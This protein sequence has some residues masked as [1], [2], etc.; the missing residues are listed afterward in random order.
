MLWFRKSP[1]IQYKNFVATF[2]I[3]N[4][5]GTSDAVS[6]LEQIIIASCPLTTY[7]KREANT[8]FSCNVFPRYI[9]GIRYRGTRQDYVSVTRVTSVYFVF[10]FISKLRTAGATSE[11]DSNLFEHNIFLYKFISKVRN[12][13]I[14]YSHLFL[15]KQ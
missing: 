9:A 4:T 13:P 3:H 5:V 10:Q 15:M 1:V 7:N 11:A 14:N 6:I 2:T 8:G 12:F